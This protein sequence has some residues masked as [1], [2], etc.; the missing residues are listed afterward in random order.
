MPPISHWLQVRGCCKRP[1][2]RRSKK[3]I[4]GGVTALR[5][6]VF[7]RL[8]AGVVAGLAAVG[9]DALNSRHLRQLTLSRVAHYVDQQPGDGIGIERVDMGRGFARDF[10]AIF[11]LPG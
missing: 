8:V 4:V 6:R 10:T 5:L 11:Q 3:E 9:V 1:S 2:L 7:V